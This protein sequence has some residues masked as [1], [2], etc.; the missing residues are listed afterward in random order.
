MLFPISI[1]EGPIVSI[2]GGFLASQKYFNIYAV[3]GVVVAGD[4]VG[5]MLYYALGKYGGQKL[6]HRFGKYLALTPER[7]KLLRNR[8]KIILEK[9]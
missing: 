4:V 3:I 7:V 9:H 1:I 8:F 5:D 2:M 6:L